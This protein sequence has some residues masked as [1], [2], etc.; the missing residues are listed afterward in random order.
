MSN[1]SPVSDSNTSYSTPTHQVRKPQVKDLPEE[2]ESMLAEAHSQ[3]TD[4][5]RE[6]TERRME[7]VLSFQNNPN[8]EEPSRLSENPLSK[9]K[10]IDPRK[11]GNLQLEDQ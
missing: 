2:A 1:I 9:G 10:G 8:E 7:K 5:E 4:T 6:R 3:L 11:W